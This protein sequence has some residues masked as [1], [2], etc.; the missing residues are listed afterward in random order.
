MVAPVGPNYVR[1][2]EN[3]VYVVSV[4]EILVGRAAGRLPKGKNCVVKFPLLS[5]SSDT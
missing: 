2:C 1:H 3:R 5:R 4:K